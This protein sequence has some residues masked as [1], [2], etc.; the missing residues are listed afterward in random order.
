MQKSE[1]CTCILE[2]I[3]AMAGKAM[4]LASGHVFLVRTDYYNF[5]YSLV[6]L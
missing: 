3:R 4:T 6:L 2:E 1:S 5:C